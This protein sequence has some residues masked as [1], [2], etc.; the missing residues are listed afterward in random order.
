[1]INLLQQG[2][3][4]AVYSVHEGVDSAQRCA[5]QADKAG[6]ALRTIRDAVASITDMTHHIASAVEEQSSVSAEV[7]R[8]VVN[9]ADLN[10]SS[11]ELGDEMV[12]LNHSVVDNIN[13]Q[14]M[15]VEQF[16]KRCQ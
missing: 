3:A 14:K 1:M 15:L 2:T 7:N 9:I 10:S 13:S 4:K 11:N 8:S 16:L 5:E 6:S 12:G